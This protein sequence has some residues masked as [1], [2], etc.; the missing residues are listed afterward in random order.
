MS[1]QEAAGLVGKSVRLSF[2]NRTMAVAAIASLDGRTLISTSGVRFDCAYITSWEL[3]E[4]T[5]VAKPI[6]TAGEG[7]EIK[8]APAPPPLPQLDQMP[9]RKQP[10][11]MPPP[12]RTIPYRRTR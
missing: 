6:S 2:S 5:P 9:I 10:I 11:A 1:P 8:S 4:T 7:A 12:G 3:V